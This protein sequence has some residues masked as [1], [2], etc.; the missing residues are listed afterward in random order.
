VRG[1]DGAFA[2]YKERGGIAPFTGQHDGLLLKSAPA[3]AVGDIL[4]DVRVVGTPSVNDAITEVE[5][6]HQPNMATGV[7]VLVSRRAME[8]DFPPAGLAEW[9]TEPDG[10]G[11]TR[12][13]R[14]RAK[15]HD[16]LLPLYDLVVMNSL[17]EGMIN[18]CN[19]GGDIAA[20]DLIVTSSKPGKGMKQ[21]DDIVR[22][23]TVAKA[24]EGAAFQNSS[25]V[26]LIACIYLCG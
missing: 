13:R 3:I 7:G 16:S 8:G 24:R 25:Q 17:G 4:C 15:K 9:V 26:K 19:E 11:G 1:A 12:G 5:Q 10:D 2:F 14:R 22:A 20:G 6:S 18:V 23:R 21:S